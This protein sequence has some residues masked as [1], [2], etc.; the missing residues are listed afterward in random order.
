MYFSCGG[1]SMNDWHYVIETKDGKHYNEEDEELK[2]ETKELRDYL[3]DDVFKKVEFYVNSDGHYIGEAGEV[4]ITLDDESEEDEEEQDFLYQ[5]DAESEWSESCSDKALF[6]LKKHYADF[7]REK[8]DNI[9]G[10]DGDTNI[11]FK[12]DCILSDEEEVIVD[13]LKKEM[14]Y[15]AAN[16]EMKDAPEDSQEEDWYNWTTNEEDDEIVINEDDEIE[17]TISKRF[18]TFKPSED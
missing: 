3:D 11:N 7:V 13:G 4:R 5:K 12:I 15:F 6:K 17:I 14:D 8:V 2:G 10:G 18:L 1:D 16:Y 9:N